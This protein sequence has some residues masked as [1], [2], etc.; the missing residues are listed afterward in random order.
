MSSKR[1]RCACLRASRKSGATQDATRAQIC[2]LRHA[3]PRKA[4]EPIGHAE[5]ARLDRD[6][7]RDSTEVRPLAS[8]EPTGAVGPA[9]SITDTGE[10]EEVVQ[11]LTRD[12]VRQIIVPLGRTVGDDHEALTTILA[13]VS[14]ST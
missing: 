4:S 3:R 12:Q 1:R 9:K 2:C 11:K 14:T 8:A 13:P 6:V 10:R 7:S 5:A